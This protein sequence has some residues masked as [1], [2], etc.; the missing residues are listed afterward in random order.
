MATSKRGR[1][2]R[3]NHLLQRLGSY[4]NFGGV[5]GDSVCTTNTK[6]VRATKTVPS[7]L[8]PSM[9]SCMCSGIS[10]RSKQIERC[11]ADKE[12]TQAGRVAVV[13]LC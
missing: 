5:T 3:G 6:K 8:M 1:G 7:R 12:S 4:L 13:S 2:K 11:H 9:T 10:A